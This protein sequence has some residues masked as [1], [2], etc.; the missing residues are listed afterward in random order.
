MALYTMKEILKDARQKKYGVGHFNAVNMEMVRA[1]ICAAEEARSPIIIGTAQGLFDVSPMEYIVPCMLSAAKNAKVPVA[2]HLDHTYDFG[3][4]MKALKSGFGSVMYDGTR[5]K[6]PAKNIEN[7]AL[8]VKIARPMGIGVECEI[9]SVS[10]LTDNDGKADAMVLTEPS[11]AKKFIEETDADFL[12]VSIGTAHGAYKLP[13]KLDIPRL[14]EI[15]QAVSVP[16]V[17]HGGSGLTDEDFQNTIAN[18]VCKINIFTDII[19]AGKE[20]LTN[21]SSAS[22]LD[23]VNLTIE[24]MKK[25]TIRKMQIFGSAGKA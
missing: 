21:N 17:L 5:E 2:V 15:H 12:A 11:D 3:I 9:G 7:S 1:Y 22:Y 6:D 14:K 13:P 10:G 8:L 4:L 24:A 23:L 25:A 19:T 20:A 16:L 18:G